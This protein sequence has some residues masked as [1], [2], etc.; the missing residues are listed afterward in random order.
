MST[1]EPYTP[2]KDW[3]RIM[4][5]YAK[6]TAVDRTLPIEAARSEGYEWFDRCFAAEIAKAQAEQREADL[7]IVRTWATRVFESIGGIVDETAFD[8][9]ADAIRAAAIREGEKQ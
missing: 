6:T 3:L 5:G 9:I 2:T 1:E 4:V 7:A 8:Q